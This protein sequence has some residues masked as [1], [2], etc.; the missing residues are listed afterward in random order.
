MESILNIKTPQYP[1]DKINSLP[2]ALKSEPNDLDRM[3]DVPTDSTVNSKFKTE[4]LEIFIIMI[5][6]IVVSLPVVTRLL[7]RQLGDSSAVLAA[8]SAL[9]ATMYYIIKNTYLSQS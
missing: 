5:L 1:T 7:E 2:L 9:F 3:Y 8:R 6:F 4:I